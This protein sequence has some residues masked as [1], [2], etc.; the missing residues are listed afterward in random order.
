MLKKFTIT[1]TFELTALCSPLLSHMPKIGFAVTV[2]H[3]AV[4][5]EHAPN[6]FSVT[7]VTQNASSVCWYQS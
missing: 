3:T 7:F 6:S 4:M 2:T 1:L 5:M